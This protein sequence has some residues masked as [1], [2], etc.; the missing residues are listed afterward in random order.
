MIGKETFH[1]S[2][3]IDKGIR[4]VNIA[5]ENQGLFRFAIQLVKD[6][7]KEDQGRNFVIQMLE[8][9]KKL[10]ADRRK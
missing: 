4:T 3:Q 2:E 10:D 7:I 8:H 9:G 5:P 1:I 6:H